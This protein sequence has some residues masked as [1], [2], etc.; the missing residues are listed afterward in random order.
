VGYRRQPCSRREHGY[1]QREQC[2]R[3][4]VS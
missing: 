4:P 3:G 1:L 2:A